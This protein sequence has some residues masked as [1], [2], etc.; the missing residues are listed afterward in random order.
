MRM[1]I[2]WRLAEAADAMTD[3]API[4]DPAGAF[5]EPVC[6]CGLAD[7]PATPR[8]AVRLQLDDAV[9]ADTYLIRHSDEVPNV[10]D[11]L[12]HFV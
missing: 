5:A 8:N 7:L 9:P 6:G 1:A 3:T 10:S 11:L 12:R 4:K 2:I